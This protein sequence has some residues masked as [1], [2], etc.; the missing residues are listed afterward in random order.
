LHAGRQVV[1]DHAITRR[2]QACSAIQ[3]VACGAIE[4]QRSAL[5]SEP[6]TESVGWFARPCSSLMR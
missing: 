5:A 2:Q 3:M 6:S 1:V 4:L